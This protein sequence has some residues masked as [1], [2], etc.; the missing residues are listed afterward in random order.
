[1]LVEVAR[2]VTRAAESL[3]LVG[4]VAATA[5]AGMQALARAAVRVE[6]AMGEVR[7][8]AAGVAETAAA[9][10]G[11]AREEAMAEGATAKAAMGVARRVAATVAAGRVAVGWVVA[12][13]VAGKAEGQRAGALEATVRAAAARMAVARAAAAKVEAGGTEAVMAAVRPEGAVVP[14]DSLSGAPEGSP[15]VAAGGGRGRRR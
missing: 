3:A 11:A 7:A 8:M 13:A 9:R 1:M 12:R 5:K 6:A 15:A 4:T 14:G 2:V 10:G